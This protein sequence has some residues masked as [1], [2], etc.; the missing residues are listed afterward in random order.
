[1]RAWP[2]IRRAAALPRRTSTRH[3]P[4]AAQ[5]W[6]SRMARRR[7]RMIPTRSLHRTDVRPS[8]CPP[9]ARRRTL[10]DTGLPADDGKDR[11]MMR[12]IAGAIAKVANVVLLAGLATLAIAASPQRHPDQDV[13]QA[14]VK[15]DG[16]TLFRVQTPAGFS[17]A[18]RAEGIARRIEAAARDRSID[19]SLVRTGP[20]EGL[21]A[22]F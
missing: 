15:L 16:A 3:R 17:A 21:T 20:S 4:T 10:N 6:S 5:P 13:D 22:V 1:M 12:R 19:P 11:A 8:C 7:P 9:G 2:W 18:Q 14:P